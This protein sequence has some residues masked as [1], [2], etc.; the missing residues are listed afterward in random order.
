[1]PES[2]CHCMYTLCILIIIMQGSPALA[3]HTGIPFRSGN[4][5]DQYNLRK[6]SVS[7][8]YKTKGVT[9]MLTLIWAWCHH[10]MA[11]GGG[12]GGG[13]GNPEEVGTGHMTK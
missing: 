11:W 1:M 8:H 6:C 9:T 2:E 10:A 4:Y 7:I 13:G 12:G 5:R 3:I